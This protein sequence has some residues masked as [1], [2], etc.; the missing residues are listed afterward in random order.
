MTSVS[1]HLMMPSMGSKSD[2]ILRNP[3]QVAHGSAS[4]TGGKSASHRAEFLN[5]WKCEMLGIGELKWFLRFV[6]VL[7]E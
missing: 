5:G 6:S 4:E 1:Q 2:S 7:S 3:P